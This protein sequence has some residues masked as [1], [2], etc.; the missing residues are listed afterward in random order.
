MDFKQI[1]TDYQIDPRQV[2]FAVNQFIDDAR[3]PRIIEGEFI[4]KEQGLQYVEER[5]YEFKAFMEK[6]KAKH[7]EDSFSEAIK[8]EIMTH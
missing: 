4:T 1:Q 7:G 2:G 5:Q 8:R 6:L 3:L